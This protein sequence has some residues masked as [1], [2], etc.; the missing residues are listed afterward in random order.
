MENEQGIR[1][2]IR[3]AII[4]FMS[5]TGKEHWPLVAI[6]R[7]II[8]ESYKTFEGI[9]YPPKNRVDV[10]QAMMAELFSFFMFI[11]IKACHCLHGEKS[12]DRLHFFLEVALVNF[13]IDVVLIEPFSDNRQDCY[14]EFCERL[15]HSHAGYSNMT[16]IRPYSTQFM[17]DSL[18][19]LFIRNL[20]NA[21]RADID[22]VGEGILKVI[23]CTHQP[24]ELE[25]LLK[26]GFELLDDDKVMQ[27][28][29]SGYYNI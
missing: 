11:T 7:K 26:D 25:A 18:F 21:M 3:S 28:I 4:F 27:K 22:V 6:A 1:N 2:E 14:R 23:S 16:K 9:N 10:G 13:I 20:T 29:L 12:S 15:N 19:S 5:S 24:L 17:D 8:D